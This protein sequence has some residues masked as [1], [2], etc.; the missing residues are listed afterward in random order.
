MAHHTLQT[1]YLITGSGA[2]GMAFA[3][4]L[5]SETTAK[6]VIVDRYAKA[7]GHW[8]VAYPFVT[9]HQPSSFYGV[10]SVELSKGR[11]D[12][13]GL[14]QGL[15]ELA[16]GADVSAYF[17]DVMRHHF[18]PSQRV[19]FFPSCEYVGDGRF[20]SKLTG[21]TY[22]VEVAKKIIDAT[23][24]KTSVPS[25]HTPSFTIDKGVQFIPINDLPKL[26]APPSE[27]VII[28]GGKTAIDACLWL[29][30]NKVDP[31]K[32]RWIM[33]RDA[34]LIDRGNT[35][36]TP[37]FFTTTFGSQADQ[38][39]AVAESESIADLFVRLES[40]GVLLRLDPDVT[41]QMFHAATVSQAELKALRR[42]KNVV[43]M[44]RVQ[45][46]HVGQVVLQGGRFATQKDCVYVDCSARAIPV[47]DPVPVFSGKVITPQTVR[48]FQPVFSAAFIAHIEA[49]NENGDESSKNELCTV[50]PL[51]NWD[52]DWVRMQAVAMM[53]QYRWS[54]EPGLGGWLRKNRLDGFSHLLGAATKDDIEKQH[55]LKRLR[56]NAPAAAMKLQQY[57]A[58]LT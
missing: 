51:P 30:D 2:V 47:K 48:P 57:A 45:H 23:F 38:M 55:I 1:D 9:L 5:L 13:V 22:Q 29:L 43:R 58:E 6:I 40:A 54:Q 27:F 20:V 41:P 44:G 33:P 3:D 18:L 7:G 37:E 10:S 19:Q 56:E 16:T 52:V 25:T 24:L 46:L 21:D 50:V 34:W 49:I 42:I 36:P 15:N 11:I 17:D 31:D 32:I 12:R 26:T 53:N 39:Q 14:N 8:N 28:G 4:T 35:Q